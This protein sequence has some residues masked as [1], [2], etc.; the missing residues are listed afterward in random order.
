MD[1]PFKLSITIGITGHM[2]IL[3]SEHDSIKARFKKLID[4][5][6]GNY[7]DLNIRV[8][9]GIA[10][11]ADQLI[12]NY[13]LDLKD[14]GEPVTPI[15]VLP[16]SLKEYKNDFSTESEVKDFS[17]VLSRLQQSNSDIIELPDESDRDECYANLGHYLIN[18]CDIIVSIWNGKLSKGSDGSIGGTEYVTRTAISSLNH[19]KECIRKSSHHLPNAETAPNPVRA[20]LEYKINN[21]MH[22]SSRILVYKIHANRAK[23]ED[24]Y[25]D[26]SNGYLIDFNNDKC[27]GQMPSD[28]HQVFSD[29]NIL[30]KDIENLEKDKIEDYLEC[31]N[32]SSGSALDT[33][34]KNIKDAFNHF[35]SLAITQRD[36]MKSI[37]SNLSKC[38]GVLALLFL[39]YAKLFNHPLILLGY[40]ILFFAGCIGYLVLKPNN[41]KFQ[42]A[43][44]RAIAESLRVEFYWKALGIIDPLGNNSLAQKISAQSVVDARVISSVIKQ[45]STLGSSLVDRNESDIRTDWITSQKNYF[46]DKVGDGVSRTS[47]SIDDQAQLGIN[48]KLHISEIFIKCTMVI[49]IV[50]CLFLLIFYAW[51]S[52]Q[53][54]FI[55]SWS[56]SLKSLTVFVI[57]LLPA[58]GAA[59]ELYLLNTSMPE[60]TERYK[61]SIQYLKNVELMLSKVQLDKENNRELVALIYETVGVELSDEHI[62]WM[63]TTKRKRVSVPNAG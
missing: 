38:T 14:S 26:K 55:H 41:I 59:T 61:S 33:D 13:C 17:N 7:P 6:R 27:I 25:F 10:K 47:K 18:K 35:D 40:L 15:A 48:G 36:K 52:E 19:I 58:L 49:P 2:D 34:L 16:M 30:S 45:S 8:I 28:C 9:T 57:G 22:E 23:D 60:S 31:K 39:F 32:I 3:E 46:Q 29:L 11:G 1:S 53:M 62:T 24:Q 4:Q 20:G 63:D 51:F 43:Q 5:F 21:L 37:H 50:L 12:T 44:T 54:F 42:F 56:F